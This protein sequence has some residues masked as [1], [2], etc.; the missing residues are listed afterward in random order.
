MSGLE[1]LAVVAI[2]GWIIF[3]QVRGEP[4]RGK[5]AVL[6]PAILTVIGFTDL[7]GTNGSHLQSVDVV[8]I[9]IGAV[10]SVVIGLGFGAITRLDERGGHLW[11]QLPVYGLW[12]WLALF[13]WR[14]V[15]YVIADGM[16]AHVAAS[17]ST[18]LFGLGLN[19]LAQAAVIVPRAMAMGVPFAPEKDGKVFMADMFDRDRA[20]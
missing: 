9:T 15:A 4:L 3:R 16:H 13:A 2:I 11:A 14:G 1:I 8:A 10:G 5:R 19:R 7:H 20:R 12:L 17:T 6:L 18:L